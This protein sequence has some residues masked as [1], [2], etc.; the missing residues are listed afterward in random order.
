MDNT[1]KRVLLLVSIT[2]YRVGDF[3]DAAQ[4]LGV[5]G[6]VGS[7]LTHILESISRGGTLTVDI[8][9]IKQGCRQIEDYH[10]DYSLSAIIGVD[11]ET[12]LLAAAAS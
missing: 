8:E 5:E 4:R 12:T 7:N 11:E 9:N 3:L 10:R 6:C 2:T 1:N